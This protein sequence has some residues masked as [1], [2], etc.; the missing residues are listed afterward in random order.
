MDTIQLKAT[1]R[2]EIGKKATKAIRRNEMVP[3]VLYGEKENIHFQ[4]EEKKLK[5]LVYT[6]NVYIVELDIDGETVEAIMQD[7][8]FHPVSDHILH[9]DFYKI[10]DKKAFKI[11]IPVELQGIAE[12][13]K[14]GGQM[15]LIQRKLKVKGLK[16]DLPNTIV[17]NV[18]HLIIGKIIKVSDITVENLQLLNAEDA[19]VCAVKATRKAVSLENEEE[20]TEETTEAESTTDEANKE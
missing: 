16:K 8:Q 5:N 18:E 1:K 10:N 15:H 17:I 12:G 11:A 13:V 3:C 9:V 2:T 20:S 4:I 14:A 19:I 7:I 6:P